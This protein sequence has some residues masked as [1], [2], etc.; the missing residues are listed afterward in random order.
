LID[1]ALG[2]LYPNAN[3][4]FIRSYLKDLPWLE[5][6]LRSIKKNWDFSKHD[7]EVVVCFPNS[8]IESNGGEIRKMIDSLNM[9]EV[10]GCVIRLTH[11]SD[12]TAIGYIDQQVNKIYADIFCHGEY[13]V[14]VDSDCFLTKKGDFN[15]F[16]LVNKSGVRSNKPYLLHTSYKEVGDAICWKQPTEELIGH[17]LEREY[18]RRIPMVIKREHLVDLREFLGEIHRKDALNLLSSRTRMSEFNLIGAFLFDKM[19]GEYDF[20]P[21]ESCT[22]PETSWIQGWSHQNFDERKA[23]LEGML[24]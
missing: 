20:R 9:W 17:P 5:L 13:I 7:G 3:S 23:Y 12:S 1:L 11:W 4:I 21:T 2:F 24:K 6:C 15:E 19:N 10:D 14:Y 22:L 16:F 18:M 8:N